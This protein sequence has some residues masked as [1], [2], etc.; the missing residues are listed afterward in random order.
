MRVIEGRPEVRGA[1]DCC[2]AG[3]GRDESGGVV[4]VA[5][6]YLYAFGD[7]CLSGGG[8]GVAGYAA[9]GPAWFLGEEGCDGSTLDVLVVSVDEGERWGTWLPVMPIT[10]MVFVM[11]EG[12]RLLILWM[13]NFSVKVGLIGSEP[14]KQKTE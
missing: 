11:V 8:G 1:E 5:V 9:D 4:E 7:P 6:D 10:T 12:V 2:G 3:A 14:R 13:Q